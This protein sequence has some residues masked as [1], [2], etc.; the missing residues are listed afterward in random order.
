MRDDAERDRV[1]GRPLP[2]MMRR[3]PDVTRVRA[4][5]ARMPLLHERDDTKQRVVITATGPFHGD[6]VLNFLARQRDD[7]TWTYA[8]LYDTRDMTGHPSIEDLRLFMKLH[9]EPDVELQPRGPLALVSTDATV[10]AM[11]CMCAALGGTKRNVGVFRDPDDADKWLAAHTGEPLRSADLALYPKTSTAED[12]GL[13]MPR[14]RAATRRR[15]DG[16]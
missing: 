11:A 6:E 1:H 14:R 7:G 16:S 9:S 10:Y 8:L 2:T 4:E 5:S 3:S 15:R 12:P 13:R